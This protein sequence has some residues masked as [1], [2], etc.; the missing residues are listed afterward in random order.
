MPPITPPSCPPGMPPG[1]PPT[2]PPPPGIGGGASSSL[3][4]CTF[5]GILVGV[6]SWPPESKSLSICF[7]ILAACCAGGGGGGGGGGAIKKVSNCDLGSSW[8]KYNGNRR[9]TPINKH[10]KKNDA[11]VA[12]VCRPFCPS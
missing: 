12:K 1:T 7:M 2:T 10:C 5:C 6:R 11:R 4:I 3:I 9:R 8:V